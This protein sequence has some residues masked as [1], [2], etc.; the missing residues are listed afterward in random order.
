MRRVAMLLA[1][2]WLA[3]ATCAAASL[4][5]PEKLVRDTT[6]QVLQVLKEHKTEI[7]ENPNRV[8][9]YVRELV[10]PHF[11]FKLMSQFVLARAW[12]SAS[13]EQ[14]E[15]FVDEFRTLLIRTYGKSLAEYSGQTVDFLPMQSDPSRGRV[16]VRTEIIQEDGPKIPLDYNLYKTDDGWKVFDVVVDGISLVQNY[17][18]SFNDEIRN[19]GLDALIQRLAK[20]NAEEGA[21]Q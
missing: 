6:D 13:Q 18:S 11:D 14:R 1:V 2:L 12:R 21:S 10:L 19:G 8:Y 17:R 4:S 5:A 20:R 16:T 3:A 15:K 9:G 7:K